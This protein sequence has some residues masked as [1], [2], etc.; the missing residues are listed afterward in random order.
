MKYLLPLLLLLS[1]RL[2]AQD[3]TKKIKVMTDHIHAFNIKQKCNHPGCG[4]ICEC[5]AFQEYTTNKIF[6]SQAKC[7]A[8]FREQGIIAD[9]KKHLIIS[10][11]LALANMPEYYHY[12][13]IEGMMDIYAKQQFTEYFEFKKEYRK[14]D[15]EASDEKIYEEFIK[16]KQ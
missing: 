14:K 2:S 5:G 8:E 6:E 12:L 10:K 13:Q 7:I 16:I 9:K 3:T 11:Y 15:K 1:F 4:A